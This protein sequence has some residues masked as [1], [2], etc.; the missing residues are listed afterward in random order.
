MN[1][2]TPLAALPPLDWTCHRLD[3][4]APLALHRIL[5]ARQEVFAIE[6]NCIYLDADAADEASWH[7]AAWAPGTVLMAYARIVDPGIKYPEASIGRVITPAVGRGRGLGR[8]LVRRA[9]AQAA[10]AWPTT[11]IRISAQSRLEDFYAGF[12][13]VVASERYLEDGIWHTE[14]LRAASTGR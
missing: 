6:Q 10:Q 14:M 13:F 1:S 12:G 8:E 9:I 3:A 11:G 4:L 5:R 7:L 2:P